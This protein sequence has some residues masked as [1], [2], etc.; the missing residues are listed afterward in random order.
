M[1]T[2]PEQ[3][4]ESAYD[5]IDALT[6]VN[7]HFNNGGV[8]DRHIHSLMLGLFRWLWGQTSNPPPP[9]EP[10]RVAATREY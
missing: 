4:V 9:P 10:G 1:N 5:A 7:D 8:Y 2:P 6:A 3:P